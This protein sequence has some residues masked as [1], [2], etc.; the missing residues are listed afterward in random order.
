MINASETHVTV[1]GGSGFVGRYV[2]EALMKAG[3]RL[4]VAVRDP[5]NAYF[6]QPLAGVGQLGAVRADVL[7]PH[8]V[9][10]AVDGADAV[11]NLIGSFEDMYEIHVDGAR[12]VAESAKNAGASALVH[13]SA[14]GADPDSQSEYGKTKGE[15]EEAVRAAYPGATIIRPSLVFGAEDDLTN[16]FA[17]LARF[18]VVPVLAPKT[19][20]QP[21]FVRDLA[22]AIAAAALQPALHS[23]KTY[24]IAGPE[25]LS[26]IDLNRRIASIAGHSP[27]FVELPNIAG[28][29]ISTFGFLPGA[30]LTS[31]QWA[32]LKHDN[33][34]SAGSAGLTD[35]GIE[36]TP[37]GA[38]AGEWLAR[39]RS[40]SRFASRSTGTPRPA[41]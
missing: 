16:R 1:F 39:Y 34:A 40:G 35:F 12:N 23:G 25:V 22:K 36:P 10:R 5:R 4:R 33:V 15:G 28:A 7:K 26:M 2:C 3:V 11:V 20:F 8:Y 38:V 14:I 6:L 9:E 17:R 31:D 18:P 13:V 24:E 19:R 41:A 32:M 37:L 21:V 30:P 27:D 29:I